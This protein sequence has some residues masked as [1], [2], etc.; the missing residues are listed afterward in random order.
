MK[1]DATPLVKASRTT[2]KGLLVFILIIILILLFDKI[3][4]YLGVYV[5]LNYLGISTSVDQSIIVLV[6]TL[7]ATLGMA[8]YIYY[9]GK[10][11]RE[12]NAHQK[13]ISLLESL[14][15][16]L[17]AISSK[18]RKIKILDKEISTQGNLQWVKE[19]FGYGLE[20]LHSVWNLNT[21]V[22]V[23]GL[24][25]KIKGKSTIR[26]KEALIHISQKIELIGNLLSKYYNQSNKITRDGMKKG[27]KSVID[28]TADLV[29]KTKKFIV[30][31]FQLKALKGQKWKIRK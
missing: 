25:R 29:E 18:E 16:E 5:L 13:Q 6:I 10:S 8:S 31:E 19:V 30:K 4:K 24:N 2:T 22:Y 26:L 21:L 17:D 14:Y 20:P 28:E 27:V 15:A 3:F 12:E 23:S 11:E 9:I 1:K 7:M